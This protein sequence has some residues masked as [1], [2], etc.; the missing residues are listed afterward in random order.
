MATSTSKPT[1]KT[2]DDIFGS[3]EEYHNKRKKELDDFI[4]GKNNNDSNTVLTNI[5]S[6]LQNLII[7][8]GKNLHPHINGYY[9]IF[10]QNGS[11][12]TQNLNNVSSHLSY[13]TLVELFNSAT[14]DKSQSITPITFGKNIMP[15]VATDID[16]PEFTKEYNQ[17]SSRNPGITSYTKD[18]HITDFNISYVE[19]G[20]SLIIKYYEH[21]HKIIELYKKGLIKADSANSSR[22]NNLKYFYEVPYLNNIWVLNLNINLDITALFLLPGV[23]PIS[24]PLKQYL[25][26]RSQTKLTTYNIQHKLTNKVLFKFYDGFND[27]I[28]DDGT[29]SKYFK[30]FI[31]STTSTAHATST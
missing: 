19:H 2:S 26:N 5:S 24:L 16:L 3:S 17:V 21:W 22:I 13:P 15:L 11:W 4:K 8:Y 10:M 29:L 18:N 20:N 25:G 12:A 7:D 27:F 9:L 1:T 28:K 30:K 6:V 14:I 31:T 23:K